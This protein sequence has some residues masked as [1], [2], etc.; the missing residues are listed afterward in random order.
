MKRPL[1]VLL[2]V[3][4]ISPSAA[5]AQIG[6][7]AG[8][9]F[10]ELSDIGG[11]R[12]ATFE[13]ANGY[14]VGLFYDLGLGPVA[15]RIGGFYRDL[16]EIEVNLDGVSGAFSLSSID[17]QVDVRFNLT[18]TPVIRPY[19]LVGPVFSFPSSG[20]DDYDDALEDVSVSG[21]VGAGI[22]LNLGGLKLFPEFRY[23]IGV[24]RFMKDDF[25][26]GNIA[27][28]S[29]DTQRQNSVMLRLGI[30]F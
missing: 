29:D 10:D 24:S 7:A 19:L 9:N 16:G 6:I 11:S 3:L 1:F 17:I 4:L 25:S 8:L 30:V 5:N 28:E 21:N 22:A 13:S 20:D 26:I 12:K 2:L 15:L 14:H 27:F 23:S 18:S